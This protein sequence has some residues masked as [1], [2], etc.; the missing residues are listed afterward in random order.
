MNIFKIFFKGQETKASRREEIVEIL[1]VTSA[2]PSIITGIVP[3]TAGQLTQGVSS[4]NSFN[5]FS[6]SG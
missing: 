4:G 3:S 2:R 1:A 6:K 5:K